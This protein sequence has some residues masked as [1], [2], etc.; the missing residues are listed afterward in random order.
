MSNILLKNTSRRLITI[1]D[2]ITKGVSYTLLPAGD[3]VTVPDTVLDLSFT[4][5]LIDAGEIL[6]MGED[7]QADELDELRAQADLLGITYTKRT[8]AK[9]LQK[10]I[11]EGE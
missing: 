2:P 6:N 1:N 7:A 8:S 11:A 9:T 10:L 5:A 3:S 4:K